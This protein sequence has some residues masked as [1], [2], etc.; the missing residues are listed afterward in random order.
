[1]TLSF[2][3]RTKLALVLALARRPDVL[4]LDEP[5][6]GLDAIAKQELFS[7]LLSLVGDSE[8]TIL[9]S[10]HSLADVERFADQLGIIRDGRMLHE[11][12]TSDIVER[13]CLV[14]LTLSHGGYFH[15]PDGLTCIRRD[16]DSS[17]S[18]TRPDSSSCTASIT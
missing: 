4:V 2:G 12:P 7:Q 18:Y 5:T 11:G 6:T 13:Y 14:D 9:I 1:M 17:G 3:S 16:D 10:S 15:V 8:R